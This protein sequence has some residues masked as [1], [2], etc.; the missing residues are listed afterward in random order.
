MDCHSLTP[1]LPK[2]RK[3]AS[4]LVLRRPT[5][6]VKLVC[7]DWKSKCIAGALLLVVS[8]CGGLRPSE[9]RRRQAQRYDTRGAHSTVPPST[10]PKKLRPAAVRGPASDQRALP[11]LIVRRTTPPATK[12]RK[13]H[14]KYRERCIELLPLAKRIAAEQSVDLS[15]IMAVARVESGYNPEAR[16]RRSGALGLMQVMPSTGRAFKCGDLRD[17][18]SNMRCGS[19]VLKRYLKYFDNELLYGIAAY[20]SG[21]VAPKKAR[22]QKQLPKNMNY[23]EKVLKLRT[24]FR[25][26]GC[27]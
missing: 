4:S 3:Y 18:E 27:G 7:I 17:A 24:R 9:I 10:A 15:L 19:R 5:A 22:K 8:G 25:R 20:H 14:P 2:P 6:T 21:P 12:R 11:S 16:N 23:V 26:Q 13:D 1:S